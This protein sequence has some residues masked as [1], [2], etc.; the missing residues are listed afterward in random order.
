MIKITQRTSFVRRYLPIA[1]VGVIVI[2]AGF[3]IAFRL[4][5]NV[6]PS[7][8]ETPAAFPGMGNAMP[9]E[10][11]YHHPSR[12]FSLK[13]PKDWNP[14]SPDFIK[15]LNHAMHT[16]PRTKLCII[17]VGFAPVIGK[18]PSLAIWPIPGN[19]DTTFEGMAKSLGISGQN[20][21]PPKSGPLSE[22]LKDG[23]FGPPLVDSQNHRIIVKAEITNAQ[24]GKM[25]GISFF[26]FGKDNIIV[27]YFCSLDA[28][29]PKYL[30]TFIKIADSLQFDPGYEFATK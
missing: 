2:L 9:L 14:M 12:R 24:I 25:C 5:G 11:S 4:H 15:S 28:E 29:M 1:L 16:D 21:V 13:L 26:C 7:A 23:A 8:A 3:L 27:L 22:T 17:D 20:Y 19:G 30:A 18:Y 10:T 6:T